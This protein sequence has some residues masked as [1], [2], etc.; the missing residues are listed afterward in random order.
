M[1]AAKAFGESAPV[2]RNVSAYSRLKLVI[3]DL[4][5]FAEIENSRRGEREIVL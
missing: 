3:Q 4:P 2:F 1:K 5:H